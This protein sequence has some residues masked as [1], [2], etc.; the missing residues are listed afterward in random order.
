MNTYDEIFRHTYMIT[1]ESNDRSNK[2]LHFWHTHH[3]FP[4]VVFG[5]EPEHVPEEHVEAARKAGIDASTDKAIRGKLGCS[6]A[7]INVQAQIVN[8]PILTV[9]EDDCLVSPMFEEYVR[10]ALEHVPDD[11][12]FLHWAVRHVNKPTPVNDFWVASKR[13]RSTLAYSVRGREAVA[14]FLGSYAKR[15]CGAD[16]IYDDPDFLALKTYCIQPAQVLQ[17]EALSTISGKTSLAP[18]LRSDSW[19]ADLTPEEFKK[20]VKAA[21]L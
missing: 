14:T 18:G 6:L 21:T 15:P 10:M 11:W 8:Y 13:I 2:T 9:V 3:I 1:L 17:I 5:V 4:T 19:L 20:Y 7:H 16:N 12:Q